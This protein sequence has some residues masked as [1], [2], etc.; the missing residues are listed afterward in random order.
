MAL[1]ISKVD[2][3]AGEMADQPGGLAR[4]L[5][6]L[7][8]AGGSLDCVIARRQPERPGTGVVFVSPVKG[9]RAPDAARGAG[10][11]QA[12]DIATLRVEGPDKPGL[13][14]RLSRAVADAGVN[15]RGLSAMV[16]GGKFVAY[17]GFDS[18]SDADRA[19]AAMKN[20]DGKRAGAARGGARRK[21]ARARK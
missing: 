10:L 3:W 8:R 19:A 21:K 6:G 17:I 4:V 5:E 14:G 12:A 20:V 2:V 16:L 15:M 11:N 9:K 7:A 13:G 1:K 18:D